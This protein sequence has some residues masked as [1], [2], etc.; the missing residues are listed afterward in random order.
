MGDG[1]LSQ[2]GS[3]RER[4]ARR[5]ASDSAPTPASALNRGVVALGIDARREVPADVDLGVFAE[6]TRK[7]MQQ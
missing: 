4:D 2:H 5:G 6:E 1:D 3:L 7:F